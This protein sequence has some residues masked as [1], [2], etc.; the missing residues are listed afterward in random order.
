MDYF[1]LETFWFATI[2]ILWIGY[3]FLEGFDFGVGILL[4]FLGKDDTDRRV[5]VNTIGP[6]WDGNEVWLLVA[7]GA[8]FAAFPEWYA[9]LFSGF[10]LPLFLILVALIIR[11]VAFEF[12]GKHD[13][14]RWKMTWDTAIVVGSALPALLWG[15]AFGNILRGVPI[16][17]DFE[18]T[19]SFFDLLNPYALVGGVTSLLLFSLHGAIY[20]TLKTDGELRDRARAAAMRLALPVAFLVVTYLMWTFLNA[21]DSD[22]TGVVP[23]VVPVTAMALAFVAGWLIQVKMDGWAFVATGGVIALTTATIFLNLYPRVMVSSTDP[24]NSLTIFNA[25][26]TNTTLTLMTIVALV[27]TPIVL[28]YQGWTYYVFRHR[29]SRDTIGQPR[30][31][32][33]LLA[34]KLGGTPSDRPDPES[35]SGTGAGA[36]GGG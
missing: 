34:D 26:S 12:R 35:T 6:V 9:T 29:I 33:D 27:F 19:G 10:Y 28:L 17:A 14:V 20:L 24:A 15:V 23:G 36:P 31:P 13:T 22:D 8:T 1:N 11:G 4:P 18:F 25:S 21:L 3:F 30:S 2:A 32:V 7:G 16:D 5:M